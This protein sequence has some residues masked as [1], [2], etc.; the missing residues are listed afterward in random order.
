MPTEIYMP[1]KEVMT[2]AQIR[3]AYESNDYNAELLLKHL[4]IRTAELEARTCASAEIEEGTLYGTE[5][6][7][8]GLQRTLEAAAAIA[9]AKSLP[10]PAEGTLRTIECPVCLQIVPLD[11]DGRLEFHEYGVANGYKQVCSASGIHHLEAKA[12]NY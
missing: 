12:P 11:G 4:L 5:E 7:V 9:R 3:E 1:P 10:Q 2:L 8:L 6:A